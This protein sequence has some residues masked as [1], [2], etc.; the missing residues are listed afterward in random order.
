MKVRSVQKEADGM[1][2]RLNATVHHWRLKT[3]EKSPSARTG[4]RTEGEGTEVVFQTTHF[5]WIPFCMCK[6]FPRALRPWRTG[7]K[8]AHSP[9][10]KQRHPKQCQLA[11]YTLYFCDEH[12]QSYRFASGAEAPRVGAESRPLHSPLR[13]KHPNATGFKISSFKHYWSSQP[14]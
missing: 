3:E 13:Q 8:I 4:T 12:V 6:S 5:D 14:L 9:G 2:I 7:V 10:C 1:V 11:N